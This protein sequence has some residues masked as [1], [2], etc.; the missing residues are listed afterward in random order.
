MKIKNLF[1]ILTI[2]LFVFGCTPSEP[3]PVDT[4]GTDQGVPEVKMTCN[5]EIKNQGEEGIDCGGPCD[6]CPTCDDGVKNQ[7]EKKVDCGG[8]CDNCPTCTDN[9]KNQGEAEI[10]CGGPCDVCK[11][12]L[13]VTAEKK[14]ALEDKM[15]LNTPAMFLQSAYQEGLAVGESYLYIFGITNT[16][17]TEKEFKVEI[18]FNRA[19]DKSS[20]PIDVDKDTVLEWFYDNEFEVYT[21]EKYEQKFLPLGV[22]VGDEI[23]PGKEP[24]AG[25]YYFYLE[26]SHNQNN[27]WREHKTLDFSFKV[28]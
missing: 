26:V 5:D 13:I 20:N 1:I 17:L 2:L 19:V 23:A 9:I 8:P 15:K 14:M 6:I 27:I 21:L 12:K 25:T 24:K 22:V 11:F 7:G 16:F 4:T 10:D 28:V 18:I 3:E